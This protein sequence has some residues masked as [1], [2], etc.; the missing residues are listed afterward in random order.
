MRV[1]VTALALLVLAAGYVAAGASGSRINPNIVKQY[2]QLDVRLDQIQADY[3]DGTLTEAQVSDKLIAWYASQQKTYRLFPEYWG[4]PF[5]DLFDDLVAANQYL[6]RVLKEIAADPDRRGYSTD[7]KHAYDYFGYAS[8]HAKSGGA[9]PYETKQ[10]LDALWDQSLDVLNASFKLPPSAQTA[11]QVKRLERK[12]MSMLADWPPVAGMDYL[13]LVR[14]QLRL[15]RAYE[16]AAFHVS[17]SGLSHRID[18]L[19]KEKQVIEN[20]LKRAVARQGK[21][22]S[23][24]TTNDDPEPTTTTAPKPTGPVC[25]A[26]K[27]FPLYPVPKGYTESKNHVYPHVPRGITVV[28]LWFVDLR[29]G[30][31]P[32]PHPFPG[33]SWEAHVNGYLPNGKFDVEVDVTDRDPN[34]PGPDPNAPVNWRVEVNFRAPSGCPK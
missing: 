15:W 18:L 2:E 3:N 22:P 21:A 34:D 7:L 25:N 1:V 30:K 14:Q 6:E 29:T 5:D 9:V 11:Q 19:R 13:G 23:T 4:L 12:K 33:Q 17:E 31:P 24:T 26:D 8:H 27:V 32:G 28:K 20:D 16:G 10:D